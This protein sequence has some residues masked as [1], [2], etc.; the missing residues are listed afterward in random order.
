[1]QPLMINR[2]VFII[3]VAAALLAGC[4]G[5]QPPIGAPG[6]LMQTR[7]VAAH[8]NHGKWW[9]KP[10]AKNDGLL[11]VSLTEADSNGDDIHVFSYPKGDLVG[12]FSLPKYE[13]MG[14]C[15][16]DKGNVFVTTFANV[17]YTSN[18]YVYEYAHA[19]TQPIATLSD[20]GFG[21]DCAI[22][23]TTGNL[24]VT[25][26]LGSLGSFDHGSVAIFKNASGT[27]TPY[28]DPDI[29]WYLWC[30]Y[31]TKGNLYVDGYN[32][33]G[34][35]PLAVLPDGSAA[36]ENLTLN[37][38][39]VEPESLQWDSGDLIIA[40]GGLKKRQGTETLY[41]VQFSGSVGTIVGSTAIA[42]HTKSRK[43]DWNEGQF[44]LDGRTL[45][46]PGF[47]DRDVHVWRFPSG[48]FP[49]RSLDVAVWGSYGVAVSV[50]PNRSRVR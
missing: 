13:P 49:I 47:N 10:E 6:A 41:K 45:I 36:F 26:A 20:P 11:Y 27:A 50:A 43:R 5:S 48:G 25:N 18:S 23:S 3:G 44:V 29:Y 37:D 46:G 4:G 15:S 16:D 24:A 33:G 14:L 32:E 28:Y 42:T 2:Y 39:Q 19:G 30:V 12:A 21:N 34:A 35:Y 8:A 1:M 31:D 40:A 17:N 7:A 22:D 9:M 38:E